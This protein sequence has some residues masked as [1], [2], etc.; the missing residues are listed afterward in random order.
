M[1]LQVRCPE[2]FPVISGT[3]RIGS[4]IFDLSVNLQLRRGSAVFDLVTSI[5]RRA[6]VLGS[7]VH[8]LPTDQM[9]VTFLNPVFRMQDRSGDVMPDPDEQTE[10]FESLSAALRSESA[11][12]ILSRFEGT[13][14]SFVA[15]EVTPRD[16]KLCGDLPMWGDAQ[17]QLAS[18]LQDRDARFDHAE[19]HSRF[20]VTIL[21][22]RPGITEAALDTLRNIVADVAAQASPEIHH[23][24]RLTDFLAVKFEQL[25]QPWVV[26]A[27]APEFTLPASG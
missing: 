4:P 8:I 14:I 18:V 3:T 24:V 23:V 7:H 16:V 21:R 5:T 10:L 22:Y 17:R 27:R 2:R 12:R 1:S 15:L 26:Q 20:H 11:Q 25:F 19:G 13:S 9:H 6:S